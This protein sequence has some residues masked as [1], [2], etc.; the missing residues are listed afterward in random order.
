MCKSFVL[1]LLFLLY[2]VDLD[3]LFF[4]FAFWFIWFCFVCP[5][6]PVKE[7]LASAARRW[8]ESLMTPSTTQGAT[9]WSL[10]P[11]AL[12]PPFPSS[13]RPLN[14]FVY[15]SHRHD[16]LPPS[17]HIVIIIYRLAATFLCHLPQTGNNSQ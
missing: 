13:P 5:E 7:T 17:C 4:P 11:S 6:C 10:P 15:L 14:A 1:F 9:W 2:F 12:T 16:H 8:R 3:C